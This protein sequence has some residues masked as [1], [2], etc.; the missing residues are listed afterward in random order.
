MLYYRPYHFS[1]QCIC[2][3]ILTSINNVIKYASTS[4]NL[5]II[6]LIALLIPLI[7]VG[8]DKSKKR[9]GSM[10]RDI[11]PSINVA[12]ASTPISISTYSINN[13][14][15]TNVLPH[16]IFTILSDLGFF[17]PGTNVSLSRL[18]K[19]SSLIYSFFLSQNF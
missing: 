17:V 4:S 18:Q 11:L 13:L 16:K 9:P 7:K 14:T 12:Y 1:S 15:G 6:Y 10:T 3:A 8:F 2:I 19:I 5:S